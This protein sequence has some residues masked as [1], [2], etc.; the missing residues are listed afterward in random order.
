MTLVML[1]N[2]QEKAFANFARCGGN[3]YIVEKRMYDNM[4]KCR[5][6][7]RQNG[8]GTSVFYTI[9]D[10]KKD[11]NVERCLTTCAWCTNAIISAIPP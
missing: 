10:L 3:Y 8:A 6:H 9:M 2:L 11:S 1:K 7:R 4:K 5:S